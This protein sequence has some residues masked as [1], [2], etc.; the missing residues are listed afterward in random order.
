MTDR[1]DSGGSGWTVWKVLGLIVALLG[2]IG[3]GFCSFLGFAVVSSYSGDVGLW[4]LAF[5]GLG[6]AVAFLVM[7]VAIVRS[8]NR[9]S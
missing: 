6:L 4:A 1:E 8:A 3:F 7:M 2:T 5:L 9:R